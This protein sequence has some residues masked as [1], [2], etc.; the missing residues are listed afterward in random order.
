MSRVEPLGPDQ[1]PAWDEFLLGSTGGL[2]Y[3]STRY[4]DLL[5]DHLG[6]EA[7][8]LVA[9]DGGEIRGVLP[10]MWSGEGDGRVCNS[11]PFY[12]S[13]GG[14]VAAHPDVESKLID[15]W[16]ERA[17]D[18][19]TLAA[20][21]VAN[22]FLANQSPPPLH[23]LTDDRISQFTP[24]PAG[25]GRDAVLELAESSARR[26]VRKAERAGFE[27]SRDESASTELHR[28]HEE[29]MVAIGG[30]AKEKTFFDAVTETLRPRE[31]FELWTARAG[32]ELAAG[33]LLLRF[34]GVVEYFTPAS[35]HDY[36]SEQPL[37][38]ILAEAMSAAAERGDRIWNWGGTWN[39]QDGVFRFKRKWGAEQG[40]YR[41]FVKL[42][43]DSLLDA[44]AEE[45]RQRFPH[46]YVVP[47]SS[48]RTMGDP[49]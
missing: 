45:L 37:A 36:R 43:D 17:T 3:H 18:P 25:G 46:F 48:L 1:D 24:L 16:N 32:G 9:L 28:L 31:D 40:D 15:A 4:R 11:L 12:G 33:L 42:N 30:L 22:P 6:C 8:Y 26:N 27:V 10:L 20:T 21:L 2:V 13:H 34:N 29:N 49:K 47:F 35:A 39:D 23:D 41:Y 14:P 19:G 44:S 7:E 5:T 38:V